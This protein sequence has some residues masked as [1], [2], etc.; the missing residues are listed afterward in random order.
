[1]EL[2][3][4]EINLYIHGQLLLNKGEDHSVGITIVSLTNGVGT[5]INK[6]SWAPVHTMCKN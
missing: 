4:P 2:S 1:M 5:T 3:V 6:Q